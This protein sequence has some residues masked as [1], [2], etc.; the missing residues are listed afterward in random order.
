MCGIDFPTN[1]NVLVGLGTADDAGVYKVTEEIALIQTVDFFTP[2]VDSPYDFGRIAAANALS[3][4]YAMGGTPKTAMNVVAYPIKALGKEVLREVLAGGAA[5]LKEAGTVLLGGHSVEDEEF[6]YGLSV[7]G[8]VHP[9]KIW[10]N[11]GLRQGDLLVLTKALGSG[12]INTAIKGGLAS[13]TTVSAA[14]HTMA[15][16]NKGAAEIMADFT[17]SSC[18]DITGF[19]LLGH[20][21]EMIDGTAEQ[22]VL[23]TAA[24]PILPE[25]Y[26][27]A[28]MGLVPVGAHN[29]RAFRQDMV[30]GLEGI[31]PVLRD[32]L[33][34]PQ[35][36]GGLLFGCKEGDVH[37]LLVRLQ[38]VGV[39]GAT[40]VGEVQSGKCEQ[41]KIKLI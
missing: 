41:E 31:D 15:Q 30:A 1:E 32:I 26:D 5:T 35:T 21:A 20:V 28:A 2:I 6:K 19:G 9:Q 39:E 10:A 22:I 24:V 40:I 36:S 7:T 34:D 25:A 3:D 27:F 4:V 8:F 38:E 13:E 37:K 18:T 11:Q 17:I 14:I 29:N 23:Q 33:F 16:L 12:I